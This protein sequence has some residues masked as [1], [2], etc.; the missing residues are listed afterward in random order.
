MEKMKLSRD[1]SWE[2][3]GIF[4]DEIEQQLLKLNQ[5]ILLTNLLNSFS[6]DSI[7]NFVKDFL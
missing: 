6:L 1:I 3:S 5:K 7:S 4:G 2:A